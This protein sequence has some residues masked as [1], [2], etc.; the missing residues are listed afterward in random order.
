MK[1]VTVIDHPLVHQCLTRLRDE[2]S[3]QAE[4]RRALSEAAALM[5]YEATRTMTTRTTRVRTPMGAASGVRL[6]RE[7][8]LVP[9]LRAGL[10]MLHGVLNLLPSARVGLVGVKRDETSLQAGVYHRSLPASLRDFEVLVLDPML[11]TGGS[12]VAALESLA[13][14]GARRVRVVCLLATPAGIR[15]VRQHDPAVPIFTAAVDR[16]LNGRG[17]I[18]PGLGDAGDRL[19]GAC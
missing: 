14:R 16:G 11:A 3:D 1:R 6:R 7:V 2:R 4:F 9:V 18:V 19:F 10:G 12:M 17:F 5:V 8:M 15:R 13:A